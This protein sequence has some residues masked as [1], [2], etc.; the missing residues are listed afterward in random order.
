MPDP[1]DLVA[2]PF[3]APKGTPDPAGLLPVALLAPKGTP[4]P[5]LVPGPVGG[6]WFDV[7]SLLTDLVFCG[8]LLTVLVFRGSLLTLPV[9]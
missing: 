3:L 6:L 5:A 4:E 9:F 1:A 7:G 2:G 8:N